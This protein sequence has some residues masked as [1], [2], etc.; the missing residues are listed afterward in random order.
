MMVFM[1]SLM[2]ARLVLRGP[3]TVVI[4]SAPGAVDDHPSVGI[5]NA[6]GLK[7]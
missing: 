6:V 3:M 7:P 4:G 2:P 5:R 1:K